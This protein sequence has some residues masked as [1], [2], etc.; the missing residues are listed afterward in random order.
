VSEV[1]ELKSF[2]DIILI[3]V[4]IIVQIFVLICSAFFFVSPLSRLHYAD[5]PFSSLFFRG[6]LMGKVTYYCSDKLVID[7][8][9]G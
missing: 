1:T 3:F 2:I 9:R 5:V 7:C 8:Q 6:V 4:P